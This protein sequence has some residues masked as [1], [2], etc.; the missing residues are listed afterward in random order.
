MSFADF[1][2]VIDTS[3]KHVLRWLGTYVDGAEQRADEVPAH[4]GDLGGF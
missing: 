2:T 4:D 3:A 1:L